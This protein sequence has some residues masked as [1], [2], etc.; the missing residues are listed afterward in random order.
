M[1][2]L[3]G[4]GS[5]VVTLAW[6]VVTA[7]LRK[8]DRGG[9]MEDAWVTEAVAANYRGGIELRVNF[10][11]FWTVGLKWLFCSLLCHS[12]SIQ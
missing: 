8:R 6:E 11:T 7:C 1:A 12:Y 4:R 3:L 9:F 2:K 10:H 5:G